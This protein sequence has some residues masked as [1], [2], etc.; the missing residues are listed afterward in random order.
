MGDIVYK[1]QAPDGSI[2]KIEGPEG[3]S[4]ADLQGAAQQHYDALQ[5]NTWTSSEQI[6]SL[7]TPKPQSMANRVIENLPK[8]LFAT[9]HPAAQIAVGALKPF[10]GLAE[11]G[12]ITAPAEVLNQLSKRFEEGSSPTMAKALDITGQVLPV[13]QAPAMMANL[14]R[15]APRLPQALEGI[16]AVG[17]KYLP[18]AVE[19]IKQ[20]VQSSPVLNYGL[21][22]AGQSALT[23]VTTPETADQSYKDMLEEKMANI[24]LG[25]GLGAA[26]GK[27]S[28]ML[29]NPKV[30]EKM[31]MLKDM[32]MK[33]LAWSTDE[34][35]ER[36]WRSYRQEYSES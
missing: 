34:R 27:G 6:P 29:M 36:I 4:E 20:V 5:K 23:P 10:A 30:T 14:A 17:G 24:G 15:N 33:Y 3:A 2:L 12:G 1:V 9:P 13:T 22:G 19:K 21:Q 31:Q 28:Q 11:Y 32:G 35:D 18:Q 16:S 25:A 8:E 26:F 7:G